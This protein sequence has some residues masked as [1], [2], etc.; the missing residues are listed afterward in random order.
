MATKAFIGYDPG[1]PA[2]MALISPSGNWV[3]YI[4]EDRVAAKTPKSGWQNVPEAINHYIEKWQ[5][6]FRGDVEIQLVVENVGPMPGEGIVS[7]CKFAGSIWLIRGICAAKGIKYHMVAPSTWK[8]HFKLSS[9]KELSRALAMQMFPKRI[10][11]LKYKK[12]HNYAE[13]A[14]LGRYQWEIEN[15]RSGLGDSSMGKLGK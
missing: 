14:L 15:E 6:S 11:R 13:A 3:A 8:R 2:T 1:S 4:G 7:A 5:S 10:H 9:D 12:D